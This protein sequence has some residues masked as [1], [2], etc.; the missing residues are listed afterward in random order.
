MI[1]FIK[2]NNNEWFEEAKSLSDYDHKN[3]VK[4]EDH[5][6]LRTK[7]SMRH[8]CILTEYCQ[9]TIW[10]YFYIICLK[11]DNIFNI[12]KNGDLAQEIQKVK[13]GNRVFLDKI[14]ANWMYQAADGLLYLHNKGVIHRDIK[15]AYEFE[16]NNS[17]NCHVR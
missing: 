13:A 6:E 3:V 11:N 14:I 10:S 16:F 17:F 7:E 12:I 15:P 1:K 9:V 2:I 8:P 4:Y 5:F